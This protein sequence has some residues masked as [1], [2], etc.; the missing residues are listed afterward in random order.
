M[1]FKKRKEGLMKKAMELSVLCDCEVA[2]VSPAP[3]LLC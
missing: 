2:L 3:E 1:T